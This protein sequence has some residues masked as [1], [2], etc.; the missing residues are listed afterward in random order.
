[1]AIMNLLFPVREVG[2]IPGFW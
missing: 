2:R 1:M